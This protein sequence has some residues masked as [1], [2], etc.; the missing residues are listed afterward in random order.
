MFKKSVLTAAGAR[1]AAVAALAVSAALGLFSIAPAAHGADLTPV[2]VEAAPPGT[3]WD[4]AIAAYVWGAS[5]TGDVGVGGLRPVDIDVSFGDILEKLDFAFMA[6]AEARY[7][8]FGVFGDLL[9]TSISTSASGPLGFVD[10]DARSEVT[11][12]TLMG[13]ARVVDQAGASLDVMAG[14]RLWNVSNKLRLSGPLATRSF[15]DSETWIDPMIGVK[16]RIGNEA[17][18]YL[19]GWA[20]A[21][22]FGVSSEFAWDL[23]GGVGYEVTDHVSVVAGYRGL[24]VDYEDDGFVYNTIQHG[25]LISGVVRF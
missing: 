5:L 9:Y 7:G 3:S 18:L 13:E 23:F 1:P 10:A 21:G 19:T 14:G 8:R 22:G 6:V 12:A 20:M 24:G 2:P 25:P 17:G 16:S 11:I 4:V 15:R